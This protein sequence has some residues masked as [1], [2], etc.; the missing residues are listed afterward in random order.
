MNSA[1]ANA[2][3][4]L[5]T[6]ADLLVDDYTDKKKFKDAVNLLKKPQRVIKKS[7]SLKLDNGRSRRFIAYR[8]QHNNARGPFKGGIRFHPNV[9]E[10]EVK[11]L[12]MWMSVKCAVVGIPYGGAK[13]GIIVD[14]VK[15]SE[16][17]L[18]ELCFKY[19]ALFSPYI[20][21]WKDVPAP[22]VNTGG[23]EMA[24]ML[25]SYEKKMGNLSPAAF[26][27]KPL[28][29]GGSE[30]RSE[31]TGL[32]GSYILDYYQRNKKRKNKDTKIAIQGFGNVGYWF[33]KFAC[34][35]GF[36]IVAISDSRGGFYDEK[37]LDINTVS[38]IKEK[39]GSFKD[40]AEKTKFKFITNEM[41]IGLPVDIFVPAALE[42]AI[43]K[44][45]A[46]VIQAK[47][48]LEMANGPTAY[49]G[50]QILLKKGIDILPDVL[51]NA[52][53]VTVSYFEWVQNL[54]GYYWTKEEVN[55]KLK[56]IMYN[57][58]VEIYK[59]KQKKNVSY[60]LAAYLLAVKRIVDAMIIRG[61]V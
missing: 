25:E 40:A 46:K 14:P 20:G 57:A 26:T 27:G 13:G 2:K 34:D 18:R 60:R 7:I 5:D 39:Y 55:K 48:V 28:E 50:E 61:R 49:E 23:R 51:C 52:G 35:M 22:D 4:Q 11:A 53:G 10:D 3:K 41:L 19:G 58:F 33:F 59:V 47:C 32:G 15:L 29:L 12:S 31:A 43:T 42:N 36:K 37:G 44:D 16:R 30:G 38:K 17:E 54:Y 6:V 9:S 56:N 8:S 1:Y 21:P 45:N 24:W